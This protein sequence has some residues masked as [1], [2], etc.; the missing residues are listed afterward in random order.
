MTDVEVLLFTQETCSA[1]AEQKERYGD[2]DADHTDV[3]VRE[4]DIQRDLA[5]A[6]EYGVRKT[7]TTLVYRGDERV[8]EF[9]GVAGREALDGAIERAR[10]GGGLVSTVRSLLGGD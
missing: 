1:C 4:V 5:T 10:A 3:T 2:V 9:V 7:P 8:A 6:E